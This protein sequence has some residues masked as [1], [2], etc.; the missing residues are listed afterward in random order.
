MIVLAELD[1]GPNIRI[2]LD[3][4]KALAVDKAIQDALGDLNAHAGV[5]VAFQRPLRS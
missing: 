1:L 4:S 3:G 2:I 5:A